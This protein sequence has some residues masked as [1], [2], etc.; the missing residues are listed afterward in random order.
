[1]LVDGR[2]EVVLAQ[3]GGPVDVDELE[4][5]GVD[6]ALVVEVGGDLG[7]QVPAGLCRDPLD[8]AGLGGVG[9]GDGRVGLGEGGRC[10]AAADGAAGWVAV[11][12][13]HAQRVCGAGHAARSVTP[14]S[15]LARASGTPASSA[16]SRPARSSRSMVVRVFRND[17][18]TLPRRAT[19]STKPCT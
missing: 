12:A 8:V 6:L 1:R 17:A 11:L 10:V 15:S 2:G 16:S 5:V 9:Q 14:S 13:A 3:V 18:S 7:E 4:G 19:A